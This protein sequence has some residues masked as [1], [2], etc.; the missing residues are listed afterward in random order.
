M[1]SWVDR[2]EHYESVAKGVDR[3]VKLVTKDGWFWR[4][5]GSVLQ[6]VTFSKFPKEDFLEKFATTIG[7][8]QAYPRGWSHILES[9]IVHESRHT[10][11]FRAFG[12]FIHPWV[13]LLP[14]AIA[15]LLLPI[16]M[17]LAWFRMLLERDAEMSALRYLRRQGQ[18]DVVLF[19][20]SGAFADK[21][22]GP[23]YGYA[24]PK[25]WTR[26]SFRKATKRLIKEAR[27]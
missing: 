14:M 11:Q 18:S 7:P 25:E 27:K 23:A 6:F 8:V 9:T 12:L 4:V 16:P 19:M 10:R 22:S 1:S 26:R 2:K 5:L 20:R 24:W 17:G 13:G 3:S 21:V 15:Y